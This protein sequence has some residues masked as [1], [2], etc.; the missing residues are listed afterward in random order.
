MCVLGRKVQRCYIS[1][2]NK[3]KNVMKKVTKSCK[4]YNHGHNILGIFYVW[5]SF[6]LTTSET[7]LDY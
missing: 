4:Y 5:Q 1:N 6:P 7:K 2:S 3:L